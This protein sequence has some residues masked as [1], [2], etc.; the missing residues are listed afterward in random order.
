MPRSVDDLTGRKWSRG[1]G[2]SSGTSGAHAYISDAFSFLQTDAYNPYRFYT[3]QQTEP[4]VSPNV[5]CLSG[6]HV[7]VFSK[8]V[9]P[10]L[11]AIARIDLVLSLWFYHFMAQFIS[12]THRR[13]KGILD[14]ASVLGPM[15]MQVLQVWFKIYP[16]ES[17]VSQS[18]SSRQ[19]SPRMS[20]AES[21]ED[22]EEQV[23]SSSLPPSQ[24][25]QEPTHPFRQA[26]PTLTPQNTS[27]QEL[28]GHQSKAVKVPNR[29]VPNPE[30][31][32]LKDS[33]DDCPSTS[34]SREMLIPAVQ[35]KS[36][37]TRTPDNNSGGI[38]HSSAHH[39]TNVSS[40]QVTYSPTSSVPKNVS[41]VMK[42]N[43]AI[44]ERCIYHFW[45]EKW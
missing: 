35:P 17:S 31:S 23:N 14:H 1:S 25:L 6:N 20:E 21:D 41:D 16:H 34:N 10:N 45:R 22:E 39:V 8:L 43:V 19:S 32:A 38:T 24:G 36:K 3:Q 13:Q 40:E 30:V 5:P 33:S 9:P 12:L 44:G 27:P 37:D 18:S 11:I 2:S 26:H 4:Y 15:T 28:H 42:E 7:F 29:S